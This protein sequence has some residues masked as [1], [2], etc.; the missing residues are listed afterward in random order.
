MNPDAIS[1][2]PRLPVRRAWAAAAAL[3]HAALAAAAASI[4]PH[5]ALA[6]AAASVLPHAALAAAPASVIPHAAGPAWP[7]P[8]PARIGDGPNPELFLMTLGEVETPLADGTFDPVRDRMQLKDG[9]IISGYFRDRLG[10]THYRPIDK[11]VFPLPPSG[12]CTWYYYYQEVSEEEV[13]RNAEWI[14]RH[15]GDYG[16]RYVQVDDGWQ[17]E[18]ADGRHGSRDWTGVDRAFPSGMAALAAHIRSLGLVPGIWIAP[19]GQ[20]NPAVVE[21]LPRVFLMK[22]DGS[23][24]SETWEGKYLL[25]P[26]SP[27]A[28]RYLKDL[29]ATLVGWGYD[30]F[31]IDGQPIVVD[32]YKA[33][34]GF[35]ARPQ[36]GEAA[37]RRTLAAIRSVI[38]PSRYLLGCWGLPLE[39]LGIM[40]GSRT[41]GDVVLGWEGFF[42]ALWPTMQSYFL[43]NIA[44]YTD[45]DVMLLRPPLTLDQARVWATLQGLTGQALFASDRLMDLAEERVELLRRVFPATDIRP[46][47]LFPSPRNKRIW[48]LKVGH[49]GRAYDVVGVFNF[50]SGRS[51][52]VR[53]DW[54]ELGIA[55]DGPVHVFDFW[56][57]EYLGAWEAGLAVELPPTSCRVLTLMKDEGAI[58]L[59]STS[60]HITQGWVDLLRLESGAGLL[61]GASRVI[62]GD[63]YELHFAFPRG[64]NHVV[65]EATAR[66]AN[67]SLPVQ[68]RNHQGW[69]TVR[70]DPA[71]TAEVEWRV[72]FAPA[73]AYRFPTREPSGLRVQ[74]VG[75]DG[76]DLHWHP[77]YYLNAGYQVYL[78]GRL[79]GYT[80]STAFPLRGLDP[81]RT[82]TAEVRSVWDDASVG[83]G[84]KKAELTFSV[85]SVLADEVDLSQLEPAGAPRPPMPPGETT[86]QL[87]GKRHDRAIAAPQDADVVFALH[88]LYRTFSALAGLDD[89]SRSKDAVVFTVSGDGRELWNSGEIAPGTPPRPVA[90][91]VAGIHQLALRVR[92]AAGNGSGAEPEWPRGPHGVWA[93]P[94]LT[95]RRSP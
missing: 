3:L 67:G 82:Y 7:R 46:L 9:T 12:F 86:A 76:V 41:G 31:K 33:K 61:S 36:A 25:D 38:G 18:T 29:F 62:R 87:G 68:V 39:G 11:S 58:Q 57:R 83:P 51:T 6:A 47:D 77:Q 35:M 50:E 14:A 26:S 80:G 60:R 42:T 75:L 59:L 16:A 20:S 89:R 94:R 19:H 91:D 53:L 23:S 90:L 49:L 5:A 21:K 32:E 54:R 78:D 63:P 22:P 10:I 93:R 73:A 15:L 85:H 64:R 95:D 45:P 55:G 72:S 1:F 13:R 44:W 74:A 52:M 40:D 30:Y 79:L 66:D 2:R 4:L 17:A 65:V 56:N 48:D 43:H 8:V 37:Y 92:P 88:G 70:I 81:H 24:A 84:H 69:A 28:L 71:R 34:K 27:A